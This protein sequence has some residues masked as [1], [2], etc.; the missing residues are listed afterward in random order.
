MSIFFIICC[1]LYPKFP[2]LDRMGSSL[3]YYT[4]SGL[5]GGGVYQAVGGMQGV[6]GGMYSSPPGP[7]P[8]GHA[9]AVSYRAPTPPQTPSTQVSLQCPVMIIVAVK[10]SCNFPKSALHQIVH[11]CK[12]IDY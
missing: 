11:I 9:T 8:T 12:V 2:F 7:A 4:P 3:G 10:V 1:T 5:P 6:S